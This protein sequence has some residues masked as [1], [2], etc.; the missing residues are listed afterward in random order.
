[1]GPLLGKVGLGRVYRDW[2][3]HL[4][5]EST[6]AVSRARGDQLFGHDVCMR[7][8]PS[9]TRHGITHAPT[10]EHTNMAK[11]GESWIKC[12]E[13]VSRFNIR[14]GRRILRRGDCNSPKMIQWAKFA[15]RADGTAVGQGPVL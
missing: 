11:R 12:P 7:V 5:S 1:V 14:W 3:L 2:M 13:R 8:G 10:W 9:W 6:L 4:V 15:K